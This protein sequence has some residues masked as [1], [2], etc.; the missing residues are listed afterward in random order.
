M[1]RF[2][3]YLQAMR[4]VLGIVGLMVC[5]TVWAGDAE[6]ELP[7][8]LWG[9]VEAGLSG[10]VST[11]EENASQELTESR[12]AEQAYL[13]GSERPGEPDSALYL[14][15][16][17]VLKAP[18]TQ[19]PVLELSGFDLPI[20]HNDIVQKWMDYFQGRG[21]NWFERCLAR[22]SAWEAMVYETFDEAGLPHDLIY[23]AMIESG[24]SN[25]AHSHA[26]AVG[27]WQF[28][29]P[30]ARGYGLRLDYW[31]DERKNPMLATQAAARYYDDLFRQFEDW[32]LSMAVYNTGPSRV[33]RAM[34]KHGT[35]D[36]WVLVEKRSLP[37]ET[38]DYV[39]KVMAAAIL[40]H[41]PAKYGF[42]IAAPQA[43]WRFEEVS[44]EGSVSLAV[45][46][47]CA[48]VGLKDLE[49]LN[50]MFLRGATPP[51]VSTVVRVP[52][53]TKETF[54]AAF[55]KLPDS[56]KLSYARHTVGKGEALG[57]I[58]ERYGVST[59]SIVAFNR[60]PNANKIRVGME[61]VIPVS[62]GTEPAKAVP[63]ETEPAKAVPA[64]TEP[65]KAV[66]AG[67]RVV[68]I[69]IKSGDN[70]STLALRHG[71]SRQEIM[72]WNNISDPDRLQM[73]QELSLYG[74]AG[75]K[76]SSSEPAAPQNYKVKAG[77]SLYSIARAHSISVVDL[78]KWNGLSSDTIQPGQLLKVGA[79]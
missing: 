16:E 8:S 69:R 10:P 76:A 57:V 32:S 71:V 4:S 24:F 49:D 73:G 56:E 40:S 26:A 53:G 54:T 39:G 55:A 61:L 78:K 36:Y 28:I 31:V 48:G 66:P 22:K 14:S 12:L 72:D 50:P 38:R 43:P 18:E 75:P 7:P 42:V 23:V 63:A 67:R 62:V 65:A 2:E 15:P 21:K 25:H 64:E 79:P 47:R 29:A 19:G 37:P 5:T 68:T 9:V 51:E 13:D 45:I 41:D 3:R 59:Q 17:K 77:D 27:M 44:I 60:L 11:E 74:T 34:R 46:A 33:R 58:A 30:T 6:T 1:Q 35:R 20:V 52:A 70:L